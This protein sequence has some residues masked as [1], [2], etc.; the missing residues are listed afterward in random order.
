MKRKSSK[1]EILRFILS[2][3]L[4]AAAV[5]LGW[6]VISY[7]RGL[8]ANRIYSKTERRKLNAL[9]RERQDWENAALSINDSSNRSGSVS[10]P[11]PAEPYLVI[12]IGKWDRPDSTTSWKPIA[13]SDKKLTDL[14]GIKTVVFCKY[15]EK[16]VSYGPKGSG[17]ATTS[18]SSEF[19]YISYVNTETGV[20]FQWE[21]FGKE[22][23][24]RTSNP[25]HYKVSTNK[26]LTHIKD[27]L[28]ELNGK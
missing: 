8:S 25:P 27:T 14:S 2:A 1:K 23:P 6:M 12:L 17:S 21:R 4:F 15:T 28:K 16:T 24:D 19:V 5:F 20:S 7:L 18:G 9:I 10:I 22:L 3:L 11:D 13:C 26:L